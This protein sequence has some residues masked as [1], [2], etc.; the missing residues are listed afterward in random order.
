MILADR[1]QGVVIIL[2]LTALR[3]CRILQ[4][5]WLP[6][7]DLIEAGNFNTWNHL[8]SGSM[9]CT[10]VR[11]EVLREPSGQYTQMELWPSQA[12]NPISPRSFLLPY[13]LLMIEQEH[14]QNQ[15]ITSSQL[16]LASLIL[17]VSVGGNVMS[18]FIP[19]SSFIHHLTLDS[20]IPSCDAK[21]L[22]SLWQWNVTRVWLMYEIWCTLHVCFP[23]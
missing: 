19:S 7:S 20:M 14:L 10:L 2:I 5:N 8:F 11:Q 9:S 15:S 1:V 17:N 21:Y 18:S 23:Q 6:K 22:E 13:H 3:I 16:K 12:P 4:E